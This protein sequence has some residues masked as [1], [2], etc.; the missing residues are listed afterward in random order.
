MFFFTVKKSYFTVK[1]F[2]HFTLHTSFTHLHTTNFFLTFFV[3]LSTLKV[4]FE[5]KLKNISEKHQKMKVQEH[6]DVDDWSA[7]EDKH[8]DQ[9]LTNFKYSKSIDKV[10]CLLCRDTAQLMEGK[11]KFVMKRHYC[12]VHKEHGKEMNVNLKRA[13]EDSGMNSEKKARSGSMSKGDCLKNCYSG[14]EMR[15][16]KKIDEDLSD[17]VSVVLSAPA[18]QVSV[19]RAFSALAVIMEQRRM[20]QRN[21]NQRIVGV[22]IE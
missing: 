2:F 17:M 22:Q 1:F 10:K 9:W 21:E 7:I 5:Y 14:D 11:V 4:K 15:I 8:E 3:C 20:S 13:A 16:N 19:E 6:P 12:T 18:T